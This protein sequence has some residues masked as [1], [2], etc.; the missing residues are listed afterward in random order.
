MEHQGLVI[1]YFWNGYYLCDGRPPKGYEND[2]EIYIGNHVKWF[3]TW[4]AANAM[5]KMIDA[6]YGFT[7]EDNE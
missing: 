7:R 5:R 2:G 6:A 4:E 1:R 3:D